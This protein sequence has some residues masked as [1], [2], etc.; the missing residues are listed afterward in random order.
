MNRQTT[1]AP[2]EMYALKGCQH[3]LNETVAAQTYELPVATKITASSI[4]NIV[5]DAL[6]CVSTYWAGLDNTTPEWDAKPKDLP[7]SQFATALL[8]SGKSVKLYD[9]EDDTEEWE[10]TLEKLLKGIGKAMLDGRTIEDI[11][12]DADTALQYA[13]FGEIVY[14]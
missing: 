13:L 5:V 8:L 2:G 14:G 3:R 9:I 7:V 6:E 4:E 12:D 10:L 1:T 11:E